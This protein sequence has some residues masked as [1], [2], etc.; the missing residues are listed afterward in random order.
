MCELQWTDGKMCCWREHATKCNVR[1]TVLL[2]CDVHIVCK[3]INYCF[4]YILNVVMSRLLLN[5]ATFYSVHH[6]QL[7]LF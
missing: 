7:D 1:Q 4:D 5:S 6:V 3:D 2:D